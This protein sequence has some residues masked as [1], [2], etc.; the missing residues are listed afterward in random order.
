MF[1]VSD[2]NRKNHLNGSLEFFVALRRNSL[3]IRSAMGLRAMSVLAL[4]KDFNWPK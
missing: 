3:S 2:G 4:V 1:T